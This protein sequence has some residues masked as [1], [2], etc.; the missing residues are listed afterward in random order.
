MPDLAQIAEGCRVF[1]ATAEPAPF[2]AGTPSVNSYRK[3]HGAGCHEGQETE[4]P[5]AT[6]KR[7]RDSPHILKQIPYEPYGKGISNDFTTHC[8]SLSR[9]NQYSE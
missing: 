5:D 7:H 3:T 8:A 1:S 2:A 4:N 6:L 9:M